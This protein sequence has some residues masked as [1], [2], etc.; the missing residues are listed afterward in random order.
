MYTVAVVELAGYTVELP[1]MD[2]SHDLDVVDAFPVLHV[3][4]VVHYKVVELGL[5]VDVAQPIVV[6]YLVLISLLEQNF[7]H[8]PCLQNL[9]HKLVSDL[10]IDG[11]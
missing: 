4:A 1:L 6:M 2:V 5:V 7:L 10:S 8:L 11:M 9:T 3:H